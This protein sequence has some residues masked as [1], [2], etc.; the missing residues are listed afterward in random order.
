MPLTDEQK[1]AIQTLAGADPKEAADALKDGAHPVFQA[2][3]R[4][5][6]GTAQGE[7]EGDDG[8]LSKAKADA[9]EATQRAEKAEAD[10]AELRKKQPDLEE[11]LEKNN[12]EWQTKL[13]KK[14][15]ELTTEREARKKERRARRKSDLMAELGAVNDSEYREFLANKY[16]DRLQ[17]RED[18]SVVLLEEP[19]ST[20][21]VQVPQGQTPFK[22]LASDI[23]KN[24]APDRKRSD[25]DS[26]GGASSGGGSGGRTQ[27]DFQRATE[28]T[29]DYTI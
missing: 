12:Q 9:E 22:V 5:G 16:L 26:G 3:F 17:D 21:P 14:D 6:Y 7:Y 13:E 4:K 24:V 15:E 10:L 8:K 28:E 20:V 25:V 1:Q 18:G 11:A 23:L 29:V 19:G 2:V 27:E